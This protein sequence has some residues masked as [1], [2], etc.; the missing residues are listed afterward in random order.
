[1]KTSSG[2][3]DFLRQALKCAF[4]SP[5]PCFHINAYERSTLTTKDE[6]TLPRDG[7]LS[8]L[9]ASLFDTSFRLAYG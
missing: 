7:F 5:D 9:P 3:G 1:M 8:R 2:W 6:N 4:Q